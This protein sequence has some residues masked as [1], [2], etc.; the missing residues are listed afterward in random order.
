MSAVT[1]VFVSVGGLRIPADPMPAEWSPEKRARAA[2]LQEVHA[3]HLFGD[4]GEREDLEVFYEQA[5]RLDAVL[6][7]VSPEHVWV[8]QSMSR[9]IARNLAT[10]EERSFEELHPIARR[11]GPIYETERRTSQF[12][13]GN[14]A[15]SAVMRAHAGRDISCVGDDDD[16]LDALES[17]RDRGVAEAIV[18]L[19]IGKHPLAP[20]DLGRSIS[21]QLFLQYGY[22][23]ARI[24]PERM[25]FIVQARAVMEYEYR[26]FV[27]DGR[28]VTGAGNVVAHTPLDNLGPTAFSPLVVRDRG[29]RLIP[30]DYGEDTWAVGT[31]DDPTPPAR[32]V[33]TRLELVAAFV[34]TGQRIVDEIA[35]EAILPRD[36]SLDL[37]VIDGAIGVVELNELSN[38]G[39]YA[40]DPKRMVA[41]LL[42]APK[43]DWWKAAPLPQ[44]LSDL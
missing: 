34:A 1:E 31:E 11:V 37:A 10:G 24:D 22:D 18:K 39:L 9:Q 27:V 15:R 19:T 2:H 3:A 4:D 26:L 36:Y 12:N 38:S 44:L 32:N 16:A 30:I 42:E 20:I 8:P 43:L 29:V 5:A 17:I 25:A 21:A 28:V 6:S 23:F 7:L 40:S 13:V 14:Y 33:E 41:A 35:A